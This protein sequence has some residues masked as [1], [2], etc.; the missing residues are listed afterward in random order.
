MSL[1][2]MPYQGHYVVIDVD[3]DEILR[4]L[5]TYQEAQQEIGE[6]EAGN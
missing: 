6:I 5:D 4:H 3:T 2:V 1:K